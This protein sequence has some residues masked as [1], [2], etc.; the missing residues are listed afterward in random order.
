MQC[1]DVVFFSARVNALLPQVAEL[2][3]VKIRD[4]NLVIERDEPWLAYTVQKWP[5]DI[6]Q[7]TL[8]I[9]SEDDV[10]AHEIA[11]CLVPSRWLLAAEGTAVWTGCTIAGHTR[12]LMFDVEH[13]D[14]IVCR[15]RDDLPDLHQMASERVGSSNILA[16]NQYWQ[17]SGRI[18]LAVAASFF[19]YLVRRYPNIA[20]KLA[21][22]VSS[23]VTLSETLQLA[24]DESLTYLAADWRKRTAEKAKDTNNA[25]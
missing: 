19:G 17:L 25:S 21:L 18:A 10:I 3:N 2:L 16:P 13:V 12:H 6:P 20:N 14:T 1:S 5:P 4:V 15:Y 7:L 8:S 24:T 11:H 22:P 9:E 23:D